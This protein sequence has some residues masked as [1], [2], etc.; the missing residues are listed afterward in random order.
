MDLGLRGKVAIVTGGGS[1]IG[2]QIALDMAAEGAITI[3]ADLNAENAA[4]TASLA[5]ADAHART[6]DVTSFDNA[7]ALVN[8]VVEEF[9]GVN[10]LVN[11][12][13]A[14]RAGLF[15]ES[16]PDDWAFEVNVCLMGVINC[17]RAVLDPMIT[18]GGGKIVNISS[19]AGR[20]GEFRQAVYSGAK[21]GVIGFSKAVAREVG[22]S[23]IH[24][25]C[26]CPGFT[27][28]PG[29]ADLTP[30]MEA[31]I[32]KAYPLRKIGLPE[33]VSKMVVFMS[34]DG[35]SH[36]TGQTISVSGGYSMA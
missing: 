24:V 19:D 1:G 3:V 6:L 18:N 20:I 4:Q 7:Q 36:T 11:C 2:Q 13:G 32:A 10:I 15:T 31:R 5:G 29:T 22:K 12:A 8:S 28:T 27:K 34:S 21:A 30:D 25:N 16:T 26:V 17:T 33:D 14:W 35:A 23:G 9:G